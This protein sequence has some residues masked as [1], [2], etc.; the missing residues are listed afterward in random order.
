MDA[1]SW[2]CV[3]GQLT[4]CADGVF[5]VYFKTRRFSEN[6]R[7]VNPLPINYCGRNGPNLF[8]VCSR[9]EITDS[10]Q[11]HVRGTHVCMCLPLPSDSSPRGNHFFFIERALTQ[12]TE[13]VAMNEPG[14]T[15]WALLANSCQFVIALC[16]DWRK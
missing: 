14:I 6:D 1:V 9:A 12:I 3:V 4:P 5:F 7:F 10:R 15:P 2:R 11:V 8:V 16:F 13:K